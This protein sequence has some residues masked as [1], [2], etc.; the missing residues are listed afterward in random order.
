[1]NGTSHITML[2]PKDY[3]RGVLFAKL[4]EEYLQAVNIKNKENRQNVLIALSNLITSLI[5]RDY[6]EKGMCFYANE[7]EVRIGPS[8]GQKRFLYWADSKFH[9]FP[10]T[11]K[12]EYVEGILPNL[13][14]GFYEQIMLE[15]KDE[16]LRAIFQSLREEFE[17]VK[18]ENEQIRSNQTTTTEN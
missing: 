7:D 13:L 12:I 1:M 14:S 5:G 2:V 15:K 11:D 8:F 10:L 6:S 17:K 16:S 9:K 3:N 4:D 18:Q